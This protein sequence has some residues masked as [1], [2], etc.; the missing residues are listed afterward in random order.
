MN[1]PTITMRLRQVEADRHAARLERVG[2]VGE[3]HQRG[4]AGRADRVA[5]GHGLGGVAD[6]VE[7]VGDVAHAGGQV[8]HLGDAAGVVGDRAVGVERDDDAGHAQHR[9][10][11]DGDAVEA[12]QRVRRR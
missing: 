8:G 12:G 7:R 2:V 4:Q 1:R 11:R 3:Q 9:R 10:G 5:L 6:G